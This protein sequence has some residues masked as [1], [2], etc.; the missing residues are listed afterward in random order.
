M[1]HRHHV[2]DSYVE[3]LSVGQCSG[4][5]PK[6]NKAVDAGKD[7]GDVFAC[8]GDGWLHLVEFACNCQ[9]DG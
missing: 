6:T 1:R 5:S 7:G 8:V 9:N 3:E 4:L 2:N